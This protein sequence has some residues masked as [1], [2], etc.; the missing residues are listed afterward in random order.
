META[1]ERPPR[2][3]GILRDN[4]QP[5]DFAD[6]DC[7]VTEWVPFSGYGGINAYRIWVCKCTNHW[8]QRHEWAR[9]GSNQTDIDEWIYSGYDTRRQWTGYW[10]PAPDMSEI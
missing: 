2:T 6:A 7:R 3:M 1:G 9:E 10:E 5:T 4:I 8:F